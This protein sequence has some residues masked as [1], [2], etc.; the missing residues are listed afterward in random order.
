MPS[1]LDSLEGLSYCVSYGHEAE[2]STHL[3]RCRARMTDVRPAAAFVKSAPLLY[4]DQVHELR[5]VNVHERGISDEW[6][7]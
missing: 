7:P 4:A 1:R 3:A 5:A 2:E 6:S